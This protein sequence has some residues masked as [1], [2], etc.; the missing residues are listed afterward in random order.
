M[1]DDEERVKGSEPHR[2]TRKRTDGEREDG[3]QAD[4]TGR[5]PT[6]G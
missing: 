5:G 4:M 6:L 3:P 1:S 2:M